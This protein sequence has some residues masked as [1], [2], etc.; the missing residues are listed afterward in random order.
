MGCQLQGFVLP[1][2][3]AFVASVLE[4]DFHL[5][6]GELEHAGQVLPFGSRE[7][8]LLLEAPLQLKHLSLG[9]QNAG[10]SPVSLLGVAAR[11]ALLLLC[12]QGVGEQTFPC[13]EQ[14]PKAK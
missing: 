14:K 10:F 2:P 6:G 4:P 7:V 8:F 3:L 11:V 1:L 13:R 9:E 12:L 5:G